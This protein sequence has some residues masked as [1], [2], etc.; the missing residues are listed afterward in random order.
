MRTYVVVIFLG[1]WS[2]FE[3][4]L[5]AWVALHEILS[6]SSYF[7]HYPYCVR[8]FASVLKCISIAAV[9]YTFI[10]LFIVRYIPSSQANYNSLYNLHH[11]TWKNNFVN[12]VHPSTTCFDISRSNIDTIYIIVTVIVQLDFKVITV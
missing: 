10:V 8:V 5:N 12:Q 7:K 9:Y 2:F 3:H 4:L 11:I 1:G 6:L